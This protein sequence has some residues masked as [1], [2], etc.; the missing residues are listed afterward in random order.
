[1]RFGIIVL[2][3]ALLLFLALV[4]CQPDIFSNFSPVF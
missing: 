4:K 3:L 2:C 1:M